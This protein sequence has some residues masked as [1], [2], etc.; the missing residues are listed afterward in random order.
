MRIILRSRLR[1]LPLEWWCEFFGAFNCA[2]MPVEDALV[3]GTL[4]VGGGVLFLIVL[5]NWILD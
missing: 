2:S 3:Y 1:S 5:M 4:S